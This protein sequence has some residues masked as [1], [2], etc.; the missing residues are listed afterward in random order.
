MLSKSTIETCP[1]RHVVALSED[2]T[3]CSSASNPFD[4]TC[5]HLAKPGDTIIVV[6]I[7]DD[8]NLIADLSGALKMVG[9]WT[10]R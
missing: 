9:R 6:H 4:W 2:D 10:A 8:A 3:S 1:T 5:T 7:A